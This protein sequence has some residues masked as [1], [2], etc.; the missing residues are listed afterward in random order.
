MEIRFWLFPLSKNLLLI[1]QMSLA[2]SSSKEIECCDSA[3]NSSQVLMATIWRPR[4][5]NLFHK[6]SITNK[7]IELKVWCSSNLTSLF[8]TYAI[9]SFYLFK[10]LH[11]IW[12]TL[13]SQLRAVLVPVKLNAIIRLSVG[14]F[15]KST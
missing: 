2:N 1:C 4:K 7:L 14:E 13:I 6:P 9:V 5:K 11:S 10:L 3:S 8:N 12:E 15:P